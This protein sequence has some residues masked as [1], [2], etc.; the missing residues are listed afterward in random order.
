MQRR[1]TNARR[2]FASHLRSSLRIEDL[3]SRQ[4]MAAAI[5]HAPQMDSA[6]VSSAIVDGATARIVNG[7]QTSEFKSVGVVNNGCTGT[8]ISPQHVLTAAHCT[9]GMDVSEMSFE[10][11]GR[12]YGVAEIHN[13]PKYND[14]QF[15]LNV[16]R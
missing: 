14:A 10:V 3:E 4:L 7:Q 8:L 1:Q 15:D 11:G 2:R 5:D 9:V 13:H 6:L 12:V 16:A